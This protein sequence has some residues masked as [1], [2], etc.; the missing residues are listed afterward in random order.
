MRW[1]I[2]I[3][4][5]IL[6]SIIFYVYINNWHLK[7]LGIRSDN[8]RETFLPHF[9]FTIIGSIFLVLFFKYQGESIRSE[10]W[11]V[12][13][14]QIF[15]IL[16]SAAQVF[17]FLSFLMPVLFSDLNNIYLAIL[18]N[19]LFFTI[20]HSIYSDFILLWPIIFFAGISFATIYFFYP[21]FIWATLSHSVLNFIVVL[22][23]HL[24][25][26]S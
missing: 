23:G 5:L 19:A 14:L 15:F 22:F 26:L 9:I 6:F 20:I 16:T 2:L 11:S 3:L 24:R 13:H 10:W 8:L 1:H 7:D 25:K 21:N 12:P 17:I 4:F 18:F